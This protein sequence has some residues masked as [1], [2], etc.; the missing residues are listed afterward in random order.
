MKENHLQMKRY[1]LGWKKLLICVLN[2]LKI[3][4]SFGAGKTYYWITQSGLL[5]KSSWNKQL[6]QI[7]NLFLTIVLLV[8]V[9]CICT[10][11]TFLLS[12]YYFILL[13]ASAF[14]NVCQD[15]WWITIRSNGIVSLPWIWGLP[16][17]GVWL[18]FFP[19]AG[20]LGDKIYSEKFEK[21]RKIQAQVSKR[22]G[23]IGLSN[24]N[25]Q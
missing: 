22:N 12:T 1:W 25:T 11:N 2:N 4:I 3:S 7:I 18:F 13:S 20:R 10:L 6:L 17:D 5:E 21:C 23:S 24:R 8:K 15:L 19:Q 9:H 14:L 16:Y